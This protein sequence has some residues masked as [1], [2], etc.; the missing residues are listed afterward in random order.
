MDQRLRAL[1]NDLAGVPNGDR[2]RVPAL[3]VLQAHFMALRR[4]DFS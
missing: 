3:K 2:T 1:H 4:L